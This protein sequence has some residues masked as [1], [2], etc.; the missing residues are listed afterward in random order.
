MPKTRTSFAPGHHL[1]SKYN[2]DY[3]DQMIDFFKNYE[4]FPTFE[5]FAES[6]MVD[7]N[8]LKNWAEK[9]SHFKTA[10]AIC[11]NIQQGRLIEGT[12]DRTYDSNFAKFLA[13]N[14]FGFVEKSQVEQDIKAAVDTSVVIN[15]NEI[16]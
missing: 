14:N 8:T 1:S 15:F 3:C 9:H 12:M 5:R 2:P 11:K 10:Y 4:K 13:I 6:I 16:K 7:N